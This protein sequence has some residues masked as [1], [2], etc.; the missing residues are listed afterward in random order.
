MACSRSVLLLL[1]GVHQVVVAVSTSYDTPLSSP[2]FSEL[3]ASPSVALIEFASGRC[4]TCKEMKPEWDAVVRQL[5]KSV[6]AASYDIDTK[7]GMEQAEVAGVLSEKGGVPAVRLYLSEDPKVKAEALV[8]GSVVKAHD[9]LAAVRRH[10]QRLN[11]D[12]RGVYLKKPKVDNEWL[13]ESA[14]HSKS[15]PAAVGKVAAGIDNGILKGAVPRW[16]IAAI[17][18]LILGVFVM[19]LGGTAVRIRNKRGTRMGS[20]S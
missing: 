17:G 12:R 20:H 16:I 15:K 10:I 8:K 19:L 6:L 9:L 5:G 7:A 2:K 14:Q 4:G 1:C 13:E 11:K 3:L 18:L